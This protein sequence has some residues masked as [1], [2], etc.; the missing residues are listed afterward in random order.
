MVEKMDL[1]MQALTDLYMNIVT[2]AKMEF[3]L[4]NY[5]NKDFYKG[6]LFGLLEAIKLTGFFNQTR[7]EIFIYEFKNLFEE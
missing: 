5:A 7:I 1:R 6:Q 3:L 4:G 2:D